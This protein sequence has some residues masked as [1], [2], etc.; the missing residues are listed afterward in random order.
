MKHNEDSRQC[1]NG[2]FS[3]GDD[4]IRATFNYKGEHISS[5]DLGLCIRQHI[6]APSELLSCVPKKFIASSVKKILPDFGNGPWGGLNL[7]DE[8]FVKIIESIEPGVHQF[9]KI[10]S[11]V[12]KRG[13]DIHKTLYVMNILEV[14][15]AVNELKSTLT[16]RE[17][18]MKASSG[19]EGHDIRTMS[20]A[21][22]FKIVLYKDIVRGRALWRGTFRDISQIFISDYVMEEMAKVGLWGPQF[23]RVDVE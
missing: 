14:I 12:N 2:T 4:R 16:I 6:R 15:N 23:Q 7:V 19:G 11:S 8:R 21:D 20:P 10:E 18:H 3:G 17:W 1:L 13:D 9:M 22:P 5:V